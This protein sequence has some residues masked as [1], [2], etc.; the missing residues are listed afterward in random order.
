M[1]VTKWKTVGAW[2]LFALALVLGSW[3]RWLNVNHV[4]YYFDVVVTQYTW[5][6]DFLN[7]GLLDGWRFYNQ[8]LDY[9]PL[10]I[11]F[12]MVIEWVG[13]LFGGG[14]V[15]FA[16]VLKSFY[17]VADFAL[18]AT[19][20]FL[21]DR[22]T[23]KVEWRLVVMSVLYVYPG[24]WFVSGVWGQSDTFHALLVIWS[25]MLLWSSRT[26]QQVMGG[27]L[28][29]I[30]L[31]F[32]LQILLV[33]GILVLFCAVRYGK[34]LWQLLRIPILVSVP[35]AAAIGWGVYQLSIIYGSNEGLYK[36]YQQY[37]EFLSQTTTFAIAPL[38]L[39]AIFWTAVLM[40]ASRKRSGHHTRFLMFGSGLAGFTS[41]ILAVFGGL[42]P[43][44]LYR[45]CIEPLANGPGYFSGSVNLNNGLTLL[46]RI[47]EWTQWSS[48]QTNV[49][50]LVFLGLVVYW[51]LSL[52]YQTGESLLYT[53]FAIASFVLLYFVFATGRVHSRYG[54]FAIVFF[55]LL[56]PFLRLR[57]YQWI[58]FAGMLL[59][60]AYNQ[61][62]VYLDQENN[63][64]AS[65]FVS[66]KPYFD[67]I[68][69]L[70]SVG[71]MVVLTSIFIA[72]FLSK[73]PVIDRRVAES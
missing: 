1:R 71:L 45:T 55:I 66:F 18:L 46:L 20:W 70:I 64:I 57:W 10:N 42:N 25:L 22:F 12:I 47:N 28:L 6:R 63:V 7:L 24:L 30:A 23:V 38:V 31:W 73:K 52:R 43:L 26:W 39:F 5:A 33:I 4:G 62:S 14:A 11:A 56:A 16:T 48:W 69:Y 19:S 59:I 49:L 40:I 51:L 36:G 68:P 65:Y 29:G 44:Q 35:F 15:A 50:M 32:K 37:A 53:L 21:L 34:E 13:R 8:Y 17:W 41:V 60:Y 54:H 9:P 27:I 2:A 3:L 61:I 58:A 67:E 72:S